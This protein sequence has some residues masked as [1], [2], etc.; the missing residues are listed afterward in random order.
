MDRKTAQKLAVLFVIPVAFFLLP[1]PEGLSLM[2]WRLLGVYIAAIVGLVIKPFGE[3]VIVL[4]AVAASA[5][6]FNNTSSVLSGYSST[7]TWMIFAA[8]SMSAA[9]AKTGLGKRITFILVDKLGRTTLGLGYVCAFLEFILSPVTPSNTAR[10]AGLE[11]PIIQGIITALDPEAEK[12]PRNIAAYLTFNGVMLAKLGSAMFITAMASNVLIVQLMNKILKI[13]IEWLFW[14]K[15]TIVPVGLVLFLAPYLLYK[16]YPPEMKVLDNKAIAAKGLAELG[17]MTVREKML[18]AIFFMALIGWCFGSYF[19][20]NA[21]AVA[22][23]VLVLS[24]FTGI[25]NWDDMLKL[26]GAWNTVIWYGGI[27]GMANSLVNAKFFEWLAKFMGTHLDFSGVSPTLALMG[28]A[29]F[30]VIVRY[31]YA[32]TGP[33]VVSML[34]VL[35][36]LGMVAGIPP[37]PLAMSMAIASNYGGLLT[38]YGSAFAPIYFAFG[39]VPLKTWWIL[40]ACMAAISYVVNMTLGLWWF[41]FLGFGI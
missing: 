11:L 22:I 25:I 29:F 36:T 1:P 35:V 3:P 14:A 2:A 20:F 13:D 16:L 12:N 39:Y 23:A 9:F 4:A 40:G 34:P 30:S 24:I 5:L 33:F 32:A 8:F 15:A 17:P 10:A 28:I 37:I 38:H 31:L 41:K 18:T 21:T 26:R 7:A 6:L 19:K 27:I